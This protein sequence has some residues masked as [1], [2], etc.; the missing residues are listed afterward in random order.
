MAAWRSTRSNRHAACRPLGT[1][2]RDPIRLGAWR[3]EESRGPQAPGAARVGTRPPVAARS[4]RP[5]REAASSVAWRWIH[6]GLARHA[7]TR[8]ASVWA[9]AEAMAAPTRPDENQRAV[10]RRGQHPC[11]IGMVCPPTA[12]SPG[13][14]H[15][16][17]TSAWSTWSSGRLPCFDRPARAPRPRTWAA[18][19]YPPSPIAGRGV[20]ESPPAGTGPLAA[21]FHPRNL[22]SARPDTGPRYLDAPTRPHLARPRSRSSNQ[23]P[24][25]DGLPT[26]HVVA[27]SR[28]VVAARHP[29]RIRIPPLTR[30]PHERRGDAATP[31]KPRTEV[32]PRSCPSPRASNTAPAWGYDR[33][34]WPKTDGKGWRR[35]KMSYLLLTRA[36]PDR[37]TTPPG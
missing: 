20:R 34:C 21:S 9:L 6:G 1:A 16:T 29:E 26:R 2:S 37:R 14:R 12:G 32:G 33:N 15:G 8:C 25:S 17:S 35:S 19:C 3:Q 30:C 24:N 11:V 18:A 4:G 10:R 22:G 23:S 27:H 13:S 36:N 28:A 5:L 7:W 31:P